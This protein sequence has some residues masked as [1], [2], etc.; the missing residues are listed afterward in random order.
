MTNY[1][2]TPNNNVFK[3]RVPLDNTLQF[4]VVDGDLQSNDCGSLS[5]RANGR[6]Y[7]FCLGRGEIADK[8]IQII[9]VRSEAVKQNI[10]FSNSF[11]VEKS[12]S[13][14][15]LLCSHTLG[16]SNFST[17]E[18][19]N[20]SVKE[21]AALD[22]VIMQNEHNRSRHNTSIDIELEANAVLH[23]YLVTLHGGEI[24]NDIKVNLNGKGG[25]CMLNGL[26]LANGSQKISNNVN[27]FHNVPE[28]F[29]RQLFKGVLEDEAVTH[30]SGTILVAKDAQK[31]EA[32]QA[33]N[34]LLAS[35]YAKAHTCPH[36]EIYADDVKCSHGATVGSLDE[37]EL[38]YMRSRGISISEAK[39]L[40]QQAF[41]YE[42]LSSIS[43][44][45]LLERLMSLVE[46]R[47][48]G[49]FSHCSNCS[50]HC[51]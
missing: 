18:K 42:A 35:D 17:H 23:L 32:Y 4:F 38:F 28:C 14:K 20:V 39:L 51:C 3:C 34:N 2:Y 44:Q 19:M 25:Q 22:L 47:L 36:L 7:D 21:N 31:T 13:A 49:E 41:A 16:E 24:S 29:S 11:V 10:E 9:S 6:G 5:R 46:K 50:T 12:A 45:E 48:R 8:L 15:L 1:I 43:N 40:Q 30:F 37:N 26:Y 27:L 33:N